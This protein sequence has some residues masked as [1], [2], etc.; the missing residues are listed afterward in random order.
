MKVFIAS[1]WRNKLAVEA[2]SEALMKRGMEVHSYLQSGANLS[3]GL[4]VV[5]ELRVFNEALADWTKNEKIKQIFDEEL[6]GLKGSDLLVLLQPAGRSSLIEA[7][8][9]YGLGKKVISIGPIEK[10]DVFYLI[11]EALY[12]DVDSFLKA[13]A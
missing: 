10:P 9:A 2:L 8:I 7:G 13:L 6:R 11:C 4:S 3:T 5:E 1:P 12:P